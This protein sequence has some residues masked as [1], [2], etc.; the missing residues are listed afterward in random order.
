MARYMMV[1]RLYR[2][3]MRFGGM[4]VY[5]GGTYRLSPRGKHLLTLTLL[6]DPTA[7]PAPL[8]RIVVQFTDAGHV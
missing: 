3:C 8:T 5:A 1:V 4:R 6:R 2:M 7:Q